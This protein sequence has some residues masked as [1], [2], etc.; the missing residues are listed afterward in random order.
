MSRY[1]KIEK[2]LDKTLKDGRILYK[3]KW[4][5][6]PLD[7]S[8]WEPLENMTSCVT[9]INEYEKK[10]LSIDEN[11]NLRKNKLDNAI[12]ENSLTH[13][14]QFSPH[15]DETEEFVS[16]KIEC[17]IPKSILSARLFEKTEVICLV[18]WKKR[19]DGSQPL[20]SYVSNKILRVKYPKLLIE[21]Y[22]Y[23][24]KYVKQQKNKQIEIRKK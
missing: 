17:D 1:Y 5:G 14:K 9:L 22:E 10:N 12:P 16:G 21:Y 8:T 24:I 18:E 2:I 20:Q 7:D 4:A 11:R 15:V 19:Y 6:W 13:N 3:V 23:K